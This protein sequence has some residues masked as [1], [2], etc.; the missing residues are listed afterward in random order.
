MSE[1]DG[2]FEEALSLSDLAGSA[3]RAMTKARELVVEAAA[4]LSRKLKST[5]E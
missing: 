3:E 1:S 4:R 2:L 5:L